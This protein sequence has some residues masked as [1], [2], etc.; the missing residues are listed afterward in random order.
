MEHDLEV[1]GIGR[2]QKPGMYTQP[3]GGLERGRIDYGVAAN[4]TQN[5]NFLRLHGHNLDQERASGLVG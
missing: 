3:F 4:G 1:T 2:T 5:L